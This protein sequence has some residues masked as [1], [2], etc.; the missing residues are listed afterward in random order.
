[1]YQFNFEKL[2]VWKKSRVLAK[3]IYTQSKGFPEDEKYGLTSQVRRAIISTCSNISEGASRISRKEQKHFYEIAFSSL[4]ECMNQVR[5]A[6]DLDYL[7]ENNI[8]EIR[9]QVQMISYMLVKL[10]ESRL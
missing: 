3:N 4:M 6:G 8:G 7:E 1:M 2:D 5:I 10:R 9:E